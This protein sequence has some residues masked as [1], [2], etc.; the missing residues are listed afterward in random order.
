MLNSDI[1]K[2]LMGLGFGGNQSADPAAASQPMSPMPTQQM[3]PQTAPILPMQM[4]QQPQM[5]TPQ[6]M[7]P[8]MA[9]PSYNAISPMR[10][11]MIQQLMMRQ[12]MNPNI[13]GMNPVMPRPRSFFM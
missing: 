10:Q 5:Q 1:L 3:M 4:Q 9:N 7:T 8:T 6:A 12:A 13:Q 2:L 11:Q